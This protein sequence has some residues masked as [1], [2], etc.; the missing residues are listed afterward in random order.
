MGTVHIPFDSASSDNAVL[1]LAAAEELEL[2]PDAV[3]TTSD[4][5]EVDEAL[6]KKA[7]VVYAKDE[8]A[9]KAPAKKSAKK[10]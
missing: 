6:A 4:G 5:F 8:P 7:G 1:L 2:G 3:A 10:K 9:K